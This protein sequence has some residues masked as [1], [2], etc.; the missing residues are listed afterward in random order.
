[1]AERANPCQHS[2]QNVCLQVGKVLVAIVVPQNAVPQ[3]ILWLT[4]ALASSSLGDVKKAWSSAT[5]F[6]RNSL[7]RCSARSIDTIRDSATRSI[8][9]LRIRLTCSL[10][11]D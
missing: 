1:M 4:T 9:R 6:H 5:T 11:S 3:T 2:I 8:A 7:K 10:L